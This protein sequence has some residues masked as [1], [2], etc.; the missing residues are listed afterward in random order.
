MKLV[1][2]FEE[3]G[4][5]Q[6]QIAGVGWLLLKWQES[7]PQRL[8]AVRRWLFTARLNPCPSFGS[9]FPSLSGSVK[10]SAM[11]KMAKLKI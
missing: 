1:D 11:H 4:A 3:S 5:E 10:I 6:N 7:V 8:K 9:L 2:C